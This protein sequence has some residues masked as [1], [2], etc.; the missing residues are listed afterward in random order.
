VRYGK[1]FRGNKAWEAE[2]RGAVGVLIYIDPKD[3]G[4]VKGKVYPDGPWSTN[5]TVQRGSVWMGEGDPSTPG[6]PS[7]ADG[8]KL[9]MDQMNNASYTPWPLPKIPIQVSNITYLLLMI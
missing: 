6:W 7:T 4:Y 8:L 5:T 2:K 1:I 3:T 9:T